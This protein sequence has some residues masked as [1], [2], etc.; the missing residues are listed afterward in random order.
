MLLL[1]EDRGELGAE[2][3]DHGAPQQELLV[4]HGQAGQHL[5]AEVR[6]DCPIGAGEVSDAVPRP[7]PPQEERSESQSGSPPFGAFDQRARVGR[8]DG[9]G[10]RG[11]QCRRLVVGER[12]VTGPDLGEVL[13]HPETVERELRIRSGQHHEA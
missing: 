5:L 2:P 12:Q 8:A 10:M 1:G 9:H 7:L 11:E 6:R 13:G 4:L 3:L